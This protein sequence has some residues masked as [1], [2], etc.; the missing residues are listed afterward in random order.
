ML[1]ELQFVKLLVQRNDTLSCHSLKLNAI[2]IVC[3]YLISVSLDFVRC[4]A[5]Y[6]ESDKNL[7]L[8]SSLLSS[9]WAC[10]C[11]CAW[12]TWEAE[13]SLKTTVHF[14]RNKTSKQV[15][16]DFR[17]CIRNCHPIDVHDKGYCF[18]IVVWYPIQR[19]L[20]PTIPYCDLVFR[21]GGEKTKTFLCHWSF[22]RLWLRNAQKLSTRFSSSSEASG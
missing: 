7:R 22:K 18:A 11:G 9:M 1:D 21:F 12:I 4:I 5:H 2:S 10:V 6:D 19:W 16:I 14:A 15:L 13:I 20:M 8:C 3:M 17:Y